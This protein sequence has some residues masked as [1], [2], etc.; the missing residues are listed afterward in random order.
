M[1]RNI[2]P[3]NEKQRKALEAAERAFCSY[4]HYIIDEGVEDFLN[5]Y[6]K[7]DIIGRTTSEIYEE[8]EEYVTDIYDNIVTQSTFTRAVGR[9]YNLRS[10]VVKRDGKAVR[11]FK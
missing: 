10:A 3:E 9:L 8:Y 11:V 4:F 6:D 7:A 1:F 5:G 2:K